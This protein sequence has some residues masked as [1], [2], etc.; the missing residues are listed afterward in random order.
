MIPTNQNKYSLALQKIN[1]IYQKALLDIN[2]L[3]QQSETL[4]SSAKKRRDEEKINQ[5]LKKIKYG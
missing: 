5:I 3:K 2:H 1:D 4:I